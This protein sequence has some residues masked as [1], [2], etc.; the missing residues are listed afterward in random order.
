M[1]K[2][3]KTTVYWDAPGINK[4]FGFYKPQH[5]GFFQKMNKVIIMFDRDIDDIHFILELF[6]KMK[7]PLALAR[8]KCDLWKPGMKP[9]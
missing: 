1:V 9:I 2:E 5:L 4:D 8:T 6:S 3:T 7:I